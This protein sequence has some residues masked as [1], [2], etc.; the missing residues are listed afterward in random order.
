MGRARWWPYPWEQSSKVAWLQEVRL[1]PSTLDSS[2]PD[3]V[4]PGQEGRP[5]TSLPPFP[6]GTEGCQQW[7]LFTLPE[8][9]GRNCMQHFKPL[10]N[11]DNS[12]KSNGDWVFK[13]QQATINKNRDLKKKK[14][15]CVPP[16]LCMEKKENISFSV[17]ALWFL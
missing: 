14:S 9:P 1:I 17:F 4:P 7:P 11:I 5:S 16:V 12:K 13:T 8:E 3:P 6:G 2:Q 10:L 15:K